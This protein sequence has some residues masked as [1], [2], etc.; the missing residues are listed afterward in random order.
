VKALLTALLTAALV[1]GGGVS[2][3]AAKRRWPAHVTKP[4]KQE[5]GPGPCY[6]DA[7]KRGNHIGR[8]YWLDRRERRH[9]V[10]KK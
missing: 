4:C 2:A 1:L 7:Q 10:R 9:Y 5:D 6:W 3:E 8:S